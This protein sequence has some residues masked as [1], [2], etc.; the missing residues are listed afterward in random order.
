[1]YARGVL[2]VYKYILGFS[3]EYGKVAAKIVST[4]EKNKEVF[5]REKTFFERLHNNL[6][7]DHQE[8]REG[9]PMVPLDSSHSLTINSFCVR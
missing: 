6:F 2:L 9:V 3:K 5:K 4:Y 7:R 8:A 1:M